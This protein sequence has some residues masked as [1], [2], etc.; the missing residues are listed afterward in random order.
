LGDFS[1]GKREFLSQSRMARASSMGSGLHAEIFEWPVELLFLRNAADNH[2]T[3]SRPASLA[4]SNLLS[5]AINSYSL[6]LD[7]VTI[8]AE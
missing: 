3:F 4:A 8:K 2:R 5:P 1:V 7:L 6:P